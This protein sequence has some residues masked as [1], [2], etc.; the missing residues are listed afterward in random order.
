MRHIALL[1][2]LLALCGLFAHAAPPPAPTTPSLPAKTRIFRI[3]TDDFWQEN[4]YIVA[5][6]RRARRSSSIRATI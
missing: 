5:T 2:G 4:C 3:V 1:I 6:P